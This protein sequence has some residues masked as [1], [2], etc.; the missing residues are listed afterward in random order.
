MSVQC[1]ACLSFTKEVAVA[2]A[3]K[4][5][6]FKNSFLY[7]IH[8]MIKKFL[9]SVPVFLLLHLSLSAQWNGDPKVNNVVCNDPSSQGYYES[10]G[11]GAGGAIYVWN[12]LNYG[13]IY[14]QHLSSSAQTLWSPSVSPLM[15]YNGYPANVIVEVNN[16]MPDGYGGVYITW[17]KRT[18]FQDPVTDIFLQRIDSSGTLLYGIN[19]VQINLIKQHTNIDARICADKDGVIITWIDKVAGMH[20]DQPNSAIVLAQRY[21]LNGVAQWDTN[22]ILVSTAPGL[23]LE[24]DIT[25]DGNGGAFIAFSDSRNSG[26]DS[27]GYPDNMDIFAQHLDSSG[28]LLWGA[29]DAAIST[30]PFSQRIFKDYFFTSVNS[31]IPDSS[32]GFIIV[33]NHEPALYSNPELY[34]QRVNGSG[35]R[36]FGNT[37]IPLSNVSGLSKNSLHLASD[38]GNGVVAMWADYTPYTLVHCQHIEGNGNIAWGTNGKIVNPANE[39]DFYRSRVAMAAD[40]KGNYVFTWGIDQNDAAMPHIIKAQ[41]LN[42][43]GIAQWMAPGILVNTNALSSA[44]D[45]TIIRSNGDSMI[46]AWRD[47]R[48]V[49]QNDTYAS[50]ISTTGILVNDI[51]ATYTTIVN[52]NWDDPAIWANNT[53]PP[54]GSDII[55][56]NNISV[57]INTTCN[58]ITIESPGILTVQ[59]GFNIT[60]LH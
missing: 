59:A 10:V 14:A 51:V 4:Y 60:V 20:P 38:G 45:P 32:G 15:V 3:Y 57:N 55:I 41:K 44:T 5:C 8:L 11:D 42:S 46:V 33:Y 1:F 27:N 12:G 19:G 53:V 24:S 52:G 40:E 48:N 39:M 9:F 29:Q 16:I 22:G 21:N 54:W 34:A 2:N 49:S 23:K 7:I 43:A 36:L 25:G 26:F 17:D 28:K 13:A 37:G 56:R 6:I 30:Q 35:T 31:M 18:S 50:K 58:S 47:R